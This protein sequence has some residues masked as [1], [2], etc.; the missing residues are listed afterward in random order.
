MAVDLPEIYVWQQPVNWDLVPASAGMIHRGVDWT[1]QTVEK[2]LV[3]NWTEMRRRFKYRLMFQRLVSWL[4]VI[5]QCNV[6]L[7]AVIA[8]GGVQRDGEAIELDIESTNGTAPSIAQCEEWLD[9]FESRGIRC[10]TYCGY[11]ATSGDGVLFRTHPLV[12]SRPWRLPWYTDSTYPGDGGAWWGRQFNCSTPVPGLQGNACKNYITRPD[13]LNQLTGTDQPLVMEIIPREAWL[14]F[15]TASWTT[16][17]PFEPASEKNNVAIHWPGGSASLGRTN[18]YLYVAKIHDE[19]RSRAYDSYPNIAY[20]FVVVQDGRIFEGRGWDYRCAANGSQPVNVPSV[21]IQLATD[22]T[23]PVTPEQIESVRWLVAETRKR[24]PNITT[25][26]GPKGDGFTGHRDLFST[27]C[28]GDLAYADAHNGTFEPEAPPPPPT[29]ADMPTILQCTDAWAA[30]LTDSM[31]AFEVNWV[32]G[33]DRKNAYVNLGVPVVNVT[34]E[35]LRQC[36]LIGRMPTGDMRVWSSADFFDVVQ[37]GNQGPVGPPG[38]P[39]TPGL[40][41]ATGPAGPQGPTGPKGADGSLV[42]GTYDIVLSQ[43]GKVTV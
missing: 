18:P 14:P 7:S 43:N 12:T 22:T 20:N 23:D 34:V 26:S 39:G 31:P 32:G 10:G 19:H 40:N 3:Q 37:S 2:G 27:S 8:V 21:A 25:T 28:P 30:F 11:Y 15:A 16:S 42:H 41:G 9:F 17:P 6:M 24:C 33:P 13:G 5:D 29:G 36:V 4:P 35:Q 38:P 1:T